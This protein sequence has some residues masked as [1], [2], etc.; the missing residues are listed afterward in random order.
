MSG[1]D[2]IIP[3]VGDGDRFRPLGSPIDPYEPNDVIDFRPL[4]SG[5]LA[6]DATTGNGED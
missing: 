4:A 6:R 3:L 1:I 5:D 2:G